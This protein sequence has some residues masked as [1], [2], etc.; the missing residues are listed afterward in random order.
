MQKGEKLKCLMSRARWTSSSRLGFQPDRITL[1]LT[2]HF[3]GLQFLYLTEYT[4][5]SSSLLMYLGNQQKDGPSATW[6]PTWS[7]KLPASTW[8]SLW[9]LWPFGEA[10]QQMED[11]FF[12]FSFPLSFSLCNTNFQIN[13]SS[14]IKLMPIKLC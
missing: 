9:L 12:S 13:K 6:R 1:I 10:N 11:L 5:S 14:K 3:S 4:Y 8:I 2:F 7:C